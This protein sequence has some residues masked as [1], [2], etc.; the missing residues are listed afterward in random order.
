MRLGCAANK[1]FSKPNS[2]QMT[3]NVP[4]ETHKPSW[5]RNVSRIL[6]RQATQDIGVERAAATPPETDAACPGP[7]AAPDHLLVMVNGLSGSRANWSYIA[8]QLEENLPP[9]TRLHVS[10]ASEYRA[11][12]L[13]VDACGRRLAKEVLGVVS[14]TPSLRRISFV[15]HSLGGLI[16]RFALGELYDAGSGSVAGLR[17]A[18]YVSLATPHLGCEGAAGPAQVPFISWSGRLNSGLQ[19]ALGGLAAPFSAIAFGRTGRHLFLLDAGE[20]GAG[21]PPL[22][23]RLASDG[24]GE[25]QRYLSALRSFETRTAYANSSGDHLVGWANSSLRAVEDLPALDF[26]GQGVVREDAVEE[27]WA[28]SARPRVRNIPAAQRLD[29]GRGHTLSAREVF[30]A[31]EA[32]SGHENGPSAGVGAGSSTDEGLAAADSGGGDAGVPAHVRASLA[33]LRG[34]SWRRVDVCFRG[35]VLPLLA[36]QHLQVQRQWV[37][38]AGKATA[39]HLA[40]QLAAMEALRAEE[41]AAAVGSPL[42]TE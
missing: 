26:R 35:A 33:A 32:G 7:G 34:L 31:E 14:E 19:R 27:A 4:V 2:V 5:T 9:T 1:S 36:H 17:P 23:R 20:A 16:S 15:G 8:R 29:P 38:F 13:G 25:R 6:R 28:P 10:T 22:L 40:L 11:T 42:G 21:S 30:G 41:G 12:Y 24:P 3:T 39:T 18:H 37:N